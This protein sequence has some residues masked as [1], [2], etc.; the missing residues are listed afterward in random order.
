MSARR[1]AA[2]AARDGSNNT[3]VT[4]P[5]LGTPATVHAAAARC[6]SCASHTHCSSVS[7]ALVTSCS[8]SPH[9]RMSATTSGVKNRGRR[10]GGGLSPASRLLVAGRA[11]AAN[12]SSPEPSN[13]HRETCTNSGVHDAC[14]SRYRSCK[15]NSGCVSKQRADVTTQATRSCSWPSTD[16]HIGMH[17]RAWTHRHE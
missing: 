8:V 10:L 14:S 2:A 5:G 3:G 16:S 11:T 17:G 1:A 12:G 15:C 7:S 9:R 4:P 6:F 13:T